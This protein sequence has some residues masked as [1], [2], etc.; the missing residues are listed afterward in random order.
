[1]W[2]GYTNVVTNKKEQKTFSNELDLDGNSEW[3]MIFGHGYVSVIAHG[4][5]HKFSD[6]N[7]LRLHYKDGSLEKISADEFKRL[8]RGHKW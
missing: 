7:V 8:N 3:L 5:E 1:M 4:K 6:K 2:V